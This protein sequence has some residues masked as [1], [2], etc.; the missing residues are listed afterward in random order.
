MSSDR[1]PVASPRPEELHLVSHTSQSPT[2]DALTSRLLA[3]ID[4]SY[5]LDSLHLLTDAQLLCVGVPPLATD[6]DRARAV[7]ELLARRERV[8]LSSGEGDDSR[9]MKRARMAS[10]V[11]ADDWKLLG[12]I[13]LGLDP[14]R[15]VDSYFVEAPAT[16]RT[17]RSI[18]SLSW[19]VRTVGRSS[20]NAVPPSAEQEP[21]VP[22]SAVGDQPSAPNVGA[23]RANAMNSGPN[24]V[25]QSRATIPDVSSTLSAAGKRL[26]A[27]YRASIDPSFAH[28]N[29]TRASFYHDGNR[30]S[31]STATS[32][33]H[34]S[35]CR[36]MAA[37]QISSLSAIPLSPFRRSRDCSWTDLATRSN[38]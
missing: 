5:S 37:A 9:P 28:S 36:H 20:S 32:A 27:L 11:T 19:D 1:A 25:S 4:F 38:P 33:R 21:L 14:S 8:R 16:E 30:I 13:R 35:T 3:Q 7:Q 6:Q 22:R 24:V 17:S 15:T 12:G 34:S 31:P 26:S 23:S 29:S 18:L 10:K 2:T